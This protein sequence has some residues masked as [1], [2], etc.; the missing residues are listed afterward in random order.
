[1][2]LKRLGTCQE[3][4]R[5]PKC[6]ENVSNIFG[7]SEKNLLKQTTGGLKMCKCGP[8]FPF[9]SL[10]FKLGVPSLAATTACAFSRSLSS[11]G[12]WYSEYPGL[13]SSRVLLGDVSSEH[14]QTTPEL[15]V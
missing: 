13:A 1:M 6:L 12:Q 15:G 2:F 4:G 10:S 14:L 5:L 7:I 11:A 8:A 9:K 3:H